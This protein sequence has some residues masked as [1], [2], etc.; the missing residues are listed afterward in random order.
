MRSY[1]GRRNL[2]QNIA[3]TTLLEIP[4]LPSAKCAL[5][6]W[7]DF[8]ELLFCGFLLAVETQRPITGKLNKEY[9]TAT[10]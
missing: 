10:G 8:G 3:K 6:S 9:N 7:V 2:K 1:K 4:K 5:K